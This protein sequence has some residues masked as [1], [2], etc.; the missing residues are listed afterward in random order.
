MN[1]TL[2][3]CAHGTDD[4][5][6]RAVVLE[7]ASNLAGRLPGVRVEVAYV[8]VQRPALGEVVDAVVAEGGQAVVVPVLLTLGYHTE[9]DVAEAVAGHRGRVISTG[10]LGPHPLLESAL[11]DRLLEAGVADGTPV[12]VGLAGSS[13]AEAADVGRGVASRVQDLWN[14]PVSVGFLAAA[15]PSVTQAVSA[16]RGDGPVAVASYLIG[17]GFFQN[18]LAQAGGDIVAGPLGAHPRLVEVAVQRY[19]FG[20]AALGGRSG[21]PIDDADRQGAAGPTVAA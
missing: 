16:A 20:A 11:V 7:I 15:E 1:P 10:P 12:V 6:G 5:A 9:V 13:R 18:R 17:P 14:G 21:N 19:L 3:L 4:P 8:D 2:V